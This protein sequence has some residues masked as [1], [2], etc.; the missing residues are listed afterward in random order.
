MDRRTPYHS[1]VVSASDMDELFDDVENAEHALALETH[2]RQVLI[3]DTP[4]PAV[5]GGIVEGLLVTGT[6]AN[7]YVSVSLGKARDNQGRRIY[8][9]GAPATVK[10]THTG[11][12]DDD[13]VTDAL[14]DGG[15]ITGSCALTNY[16]I[17]SLWIVYSQVQSNPKVDGLG[18]TIQ[19]DLE[20]SFHFEIQIMTAFPNPPVATP[21]RPALADGKVLLAD[22]ILTNSGGNIILV[23]VMETTPDWITRAGYYANLEGRRSSWL[24]VQSTD[25]FAVAD[26]SKDIIRAA[27]A[28][29][30]LYD[31]GK[32][33]RSQAVIVHRP[34]AVA[35]LF[36]KVGLYGHPAIPEVFHDPMMHTEN[37]VTLAAGAGNIPGWFILPITGIL[38][39]PADNY[40]SA[41]T[42]ALGGLVCLNTK[43]IATQGL[44]MMTKHAW[45][46]GASPWC[47][48]QFRFSMATGFTNTDFYIG[49]NNGGVVAGNDLIYAMYNSATG[50]LSGRCAGNTGVGGTAV[51]LTAALTPD[52][53]HTLRICVVN[54]ASV[55]FQLDDGAWTEATPNGV[56]QFT[57][58]LY[59]LYIGAW[60]AGAA[61]GY[62]GISQAYA[63]A[64]Q[65]DSDQA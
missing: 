13:D 29:E 52:V 12:T 34:K 47:I 25:E 9:P 65:L 40:L 39:A 26:A 45:N 3:A 48:T 57:D 23:D 10:I 38:G 53:N 20:E 43:N 11:V 55:F 21:T 35:E 49:L 14:G 24:T 1:Q 51:T 54:A 46:A 7:D 36:S 44:E 32:K 60:S 4:D 56:D 31:L 42:N 15:A 19:Y 2:T 16:I 61:P 58:S 8:M 41:P 59:R 5:Y 33:V 30:A 63:A 28:R 18:A 64:G 37:Q 50:V 27:S 17:A 22:L 6:P 62:L